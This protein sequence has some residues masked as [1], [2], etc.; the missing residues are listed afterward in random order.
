MTSLWLKPCCPFSCR[1]FCEFSALVM[2]KYYYGV[3]QV[4]PSSLS[5]GG[6]AVTRVVQKVGHFVIVFPEVRTKPF[7]TYIHR[8]PP[9]DRTLYS[10]Q[11]S[12]VSTSYQGSIFFLCVSLS[13]SRGGKG[14]NENLG[15]RLPLLSKLKMEAT[16]PGSKYLAFV[17]LS[18]SLRYHL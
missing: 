5:D 18:T 15:T 10:F 11:S 6:V 14:R 8:P 4:S 16:H 1:I 12:S 9:V 17:R 2:I 3:R 13:R 7:F